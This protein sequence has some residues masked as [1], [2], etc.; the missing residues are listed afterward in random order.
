MYPNVNILNLTNY[1]LK[2]FN[3]KGQNESIQIFAHVK[4]DLKSRQ[5]F[6]PHTP[7]A[8]D[9]VIWNSI[10]TKHLFNFSNLPNAKIQNQ[11]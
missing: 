5:H 9:F 10:F 2:H 4:F 1:I 7:H 3:H 8:L 11:K 6:F